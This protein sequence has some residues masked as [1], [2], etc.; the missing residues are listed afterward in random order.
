MIKRFGA[1]SVVVWM[2][3][4]GGGEE[5]AP[6]AEIPVTPT[7][8]APSVPTPP[9]TA[10]EG[11]VEGAT[12]PPSTPA[13][14]TAAGTGVVVAPPPGM[15]P[16]AP[17]PQV[18]KGAPKTSVT[19]EELVTAR[20]NYHKLLV[21]IHKAHANIVKNNGGK[22][23]K[24]PVTGEIQANRYDVDGDGPGRVMEILV[25]GGYL[26]N[27]IT[28]STG[29]VVD[30]CNAVV[31]ANTITNEDVDWHYCAA[32][33]RLIPSGG[34]TNEPV[35]QWAMD[36]NQIGKDRAIASANGVPPAAAPSTSG[37]APAAAG[38][39]PAVGPNT[40]ASPGA[41]GTAPPPARPPSAAGGT[42][43]PKP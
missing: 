22:G 11:T 36:E 7:E 16:A 39:V 41:R 35:M 17:A 20:V 12:P 43:A 30:Y 5:V 15:P 13:A 23:S 26:A 9:P 8:E 19:K 33:G 27:P 31:V 28:P 40:P 32:T 34:Y 4:C 38:K 42:P 2:G 21:A 3:A 10:P 25:E 29:Q 14:G 24:W 18:W 1:L 37:M 6:P